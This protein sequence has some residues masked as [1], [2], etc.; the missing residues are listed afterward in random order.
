MVAKA[1]AGAHPQVVVLHAQ[2]AVALLLDAGIG[3]LAV[4]TGAAGDRHGDVR[5][6]ELRVLVLL[7]HVGGRWDNGA[8][9]HGADL[10]VLLLQVVMVVLLV[11]LLVL[12][13][14]VRRCLSI[15]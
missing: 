11:L 7:L 5:G 6:R 2:K 3:A 1:A 15:D 4:G 9:G 13:D 8:R 14:L 10:L 12:V